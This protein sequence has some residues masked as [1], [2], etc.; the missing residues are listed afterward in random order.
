MEGL[1]VGGRYRILAPLGAG[2]MGLVYE[3][4]HVARSLCSV[5]SDPDHFCFPCSAWRA[6]LRVPGAP[7]VR[8]Q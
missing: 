1:V 8:A 4:E 7:H 3:A 6:K 5:R 2:G